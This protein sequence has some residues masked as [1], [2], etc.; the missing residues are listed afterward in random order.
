MP[1]I[2]ANDIDVYYEITGSGDPLVL[3]A[4]LGY[5]MWMWRK[6]IPGLAEHFQVIAFDNR[7]VGQTDKPAGPYTARLLADDTA[8]LIKALG[9]QS[10]N[11]LGHSMGGFVAQALAL[12]YPELLDKLIL[13]ATNFGG[14]RHVPVTPQAMAVLTDVSGDPL[15]RLKR[16]ILISCTPGFGEAHPEIV[17]EWLDYRVA[18]PLQPAPYQAQLAIGL[19]LVSEEACF[20]HKLPQVQTPTLILF[21]EHDQ[22]VPPAN[23]A[24][25]DAAL[26]NSTVKILPNAGHFLSLDATDAAVEA[27]VEFLKA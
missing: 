16:G 22:V 11:V 6:M 20:E 24:L 2:R 21:G 15:E 5:D 10:V 14:P 7:G 3:I 17:Q 1:K 12:D 18:N 23:A 4:G 9:F 13:S 19:G 8:G 27:V 26:P 25:L